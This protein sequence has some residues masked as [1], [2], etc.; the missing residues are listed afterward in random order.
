MLLPRRAP[1]RW[2]RNACCGL[3][4]SLPPWIQDTSQLAIW[5]ALCRELAS[6]GPDPQQGSMSLA[7]FSHLKYCPL[8]DAVEPEA[9]HMPLLPRL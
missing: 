5:I 1:K 9:Q 7:S 4:S 6:S 2:V 3:S 8:N